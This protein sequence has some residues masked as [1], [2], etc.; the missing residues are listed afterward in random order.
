M[1]GLLVCA[2]VLVRCWSCVRVVVVRSGVFVSLRE[3]FDSGNSV[4]SLEV[5]VEFLKNLACDERVVEFIVNEGFLVRIVELLS[6]GVLGVRVQCAKAVFR[7]GCNAKARKELGELG[8]IGPLIGMLDGKA[9]EEKQAAVKALSVILVCSGNRR[10]YRKE[11]RGIV[12]VVQ[13]LDPSIP[14][15]DKKYPVSI[16]MSLSHSKKCRKQMVNSG[17]LLFLQ[18][19]V[20]M[21]VEGAKKLQESIGRAKL[22]GVFG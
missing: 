1:L 7:L 17:A 5:A 16:L 6:C 20:E 22:W 11:E 12:S 21:E 14:N 8:C 9:V 13:L 3:F 19:L 15:F 2:V 4:R 18:K 10:I